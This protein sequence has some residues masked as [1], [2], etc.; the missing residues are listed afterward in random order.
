MEELSGFELLP[1]FYK[2]AAFQNYPD[3]KMEYRVILISE[4]EKAIPKENLTCLG[5]LPGEDMLPFQGHDRWT[6]YYPVG[7]ESGKYNSKFE[8]YVIDQY[9]AW[10]DVKL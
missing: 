2:P 9:L 6:G 10:R 1:A 7:W 8:H 3:M 4:S 5:N